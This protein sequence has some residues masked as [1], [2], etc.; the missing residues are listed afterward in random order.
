MLTKHDT[1]P[2]WVYGDDKDRIPFTRGTIQMDKHD[3]KTAM[4]MFYEESGWDRETGSLTRESYHRLGLESVA[5]E[6]DK[7]GLIV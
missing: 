7:K 1:I 2:D 4:R 3:M 5:R 6:L